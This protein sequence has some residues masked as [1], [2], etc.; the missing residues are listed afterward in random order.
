[1]AQAAQRRS[2]IS[3]NWGA[4]RET[5]WEVSVDVNCLIELVR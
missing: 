4:K 3:K 2:G 1:V 5:L